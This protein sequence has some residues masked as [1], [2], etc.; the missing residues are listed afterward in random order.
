LRRISSIYVVITIFIT[1]SDVFLEAPEN[2]VTAAAEVKS[3]IWKISVNFIDV[4]SVSK[5]PI[6]DLLKFFK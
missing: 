3:E 5:V 2:S 6:I 1:D 4:I